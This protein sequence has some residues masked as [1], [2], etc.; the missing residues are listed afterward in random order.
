MSVKVNADHGSAFSKYWEH[1]SEHFD[2]AQPSVQQQE[3][4]PLS[5]DLVVVT[6]S[7]G[8]HMTAFDVRLHHASPRLNKTSRR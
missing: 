1:W 8:R 7:V 3:G 6:H 5:V 2:L 4:F